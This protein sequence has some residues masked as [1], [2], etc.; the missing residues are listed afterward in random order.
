MAPV[1]SANVTRFRSTINRRS[2]SLATVACSGS[3]AILNPDRR[4]SL[5]RPGVSRCAA[6]PRSGYAGRIPV[7]P[8]R[9]PQGT[10]ERLLASVI[11]ASLQSAGRHR[12]VVIA[13]RSFR[14][15]LRS[16]RRQTEA[17]IPLAVFLLR[18]PWPRLVLLLLFLLF[19][20]RQLLL[21][22]FFLVFLATLVSH[23]CSCPL[24]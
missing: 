18:S 9:T 13:R 23:A 3:H 15:A 2:A 16:V 1:A 21:L 6:A 10:A 20:F 12:R 8:R 14:A 24:V 4:L 5:A 22:A 11:P 7:P 19:L 17:P